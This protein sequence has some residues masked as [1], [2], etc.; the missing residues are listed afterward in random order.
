MAG[1]HGIGMNEDIMLIRYVRPVLWIKWYFHI[2]DPKV[3]C[4]YR[5]SVV[6]RLT[7][8]APRLDEPGARGGVCYAPLPC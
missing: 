7:P 2:V 6:H 4:S 3:T 1:K 5:S 8:L